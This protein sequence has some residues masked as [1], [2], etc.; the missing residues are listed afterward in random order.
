MIITHVV[1]KGEEEVELDDASAYLITKNL[2]R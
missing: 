1:E 2:Q